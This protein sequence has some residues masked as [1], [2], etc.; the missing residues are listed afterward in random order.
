M[1]PPHAALPVIRTVLRGLSQI[2]LQENAWCGA[3][4]LAAIALQAWTWALA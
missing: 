1:A 4:L 3:M 2:F